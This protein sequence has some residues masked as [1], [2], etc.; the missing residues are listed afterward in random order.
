MRILQWTAETLIS[1]MEIGLIRIMKAV[2][3]DTTFIQPE[4]KIGVRSKK[5]A[6]LPQVNPFGFCSKFYSFKIRNN[7]LS[8]RIF[9]FPLK[10]IKC[11]T[12]PQRKL[13]CCGFK[14]WSISARI[15]R[16]NAK[17]LQHFRPVCRDPNTTH[18]LMGCLNKR[19]DLNE[20]ALTPSLEDGSL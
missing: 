2:K 11:R 13:T 12:N 7:K 1:P 18:W 19:S 4:S 16:S 10:T 5:F 15:W 14:F 20:C 3:S 17:N 9:T 6:E 8:L